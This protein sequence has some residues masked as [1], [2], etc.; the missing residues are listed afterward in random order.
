MPE[1]LSYGAGLTKL[2]YVKFILILM[3][4]AI[5]GASIFVFLG[6]MLKGDQST[7][8]GLGFPA[9]SAVVALIG[10]YLFAQSIRKR[11]QDA[12]EL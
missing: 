2:S 5:T 9:V 7:L 12:P 8:I 1:L 4:I 11:H 6:S 10:G 3:P